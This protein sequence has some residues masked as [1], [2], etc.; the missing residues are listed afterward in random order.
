MKETKHA[1][2]AGSQSPSHEY[3]PWELTAETAALCWRRPAGL[4]K[5]GRGASSWGD[6]EE[7]ENRRGVQS[8]CHLSLG[9]HASLVQTLQR[10][11]PL[12]L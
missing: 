4:R 10:Q 5:V 2:Q 11:E 12:G 8:P 1:T 9:T 3:P 7:E 6:Q